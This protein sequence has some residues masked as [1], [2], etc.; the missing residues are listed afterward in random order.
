MEQNRYRLYDEI[1]KVMK[2]FT[3]SIPYVTDCKPIM[4]YKNTDNSL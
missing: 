3:F 1:V 2:N 4:A